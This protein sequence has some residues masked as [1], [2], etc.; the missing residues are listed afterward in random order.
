MQL[1]WVMRCKVS[2]AAQAG[3]LGQSLHCFT[4]TLGLLPWVTGASRLHKLVL[5]AKEA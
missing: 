3:V 2:A 1:R 5:W 4:L